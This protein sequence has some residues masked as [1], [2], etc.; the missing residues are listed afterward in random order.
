MLRQRHPA[1]LASL[2][3]GDVLVSHST[4]VREHGI[5]IVPNARHATFPTHD[6]AVVEGRSQA[7]ARGV[8]AWLS[9]DQTHV[10]KIAS[11]RI[12]RT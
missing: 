7:E 3:A 11:H 6:A 9:E 2:Q 8:D 4:A 1:S 5:S 10:M 12:R